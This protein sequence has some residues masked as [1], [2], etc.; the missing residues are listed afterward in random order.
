LIRRVPLDASFAAR[1]PNAQRVAFRKLC[2]AVRAGD[3]RSS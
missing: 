3:R 2:R 1:L